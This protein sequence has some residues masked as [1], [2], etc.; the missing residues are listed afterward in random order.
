M[1]GEIIVGAL[2][3]A[4][5]LIWGFLMG[6]IITDRY[7]GFGDK[8]F[9]GLLFTSIGVAAFLFVYAFIPT[10]TTTSEVTD[11]KYVKNEQAAVYLNDEDYTHTENAFLYK[12]AGDTSKVE[13]LEVQWKN[14]EG[15]FVG[16]TIRVNQKE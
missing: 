9:M 7:L 2:L 1:I 10:T 3:A 13:V 15:S 4:I 16:T 14:I 5:V 6:D 11:Y 8:V 12:N